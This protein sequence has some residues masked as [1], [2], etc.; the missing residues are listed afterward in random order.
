MHINIKTII[1]LTAGKTDSIQSSS[2]FDKM[3]NQSLLNYIKNSRYVYVPAIGKFSGN[4][5]APYAVFNM[6]IDTAKSLC[7]RH[8]QMSF[9]FTQLLDGGS[10]H[11]E[12]W[13]KRDRD[14]S[15]NRKKNDYIKKDEYDGWMD[16]AAAENNFTI[17]GNKFQY[18]IPFSI[19]ESVNNLFTN[20]IKHIIE[21]A[22]KR[23]NQTLNRDRILDCTMN[24]VGMPPYLWRGGL[25]K[26]FYKD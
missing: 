18:Q 3:G 13:E 7:G 19:F 25:I 16:M 12:F 26:G 14:S 15:Y 1:V 5:D 20:N 10:V 23:G 2:Q 11:S 24:R 21:R 4:A 22:K 8:Q 9:V 6:S 17:I